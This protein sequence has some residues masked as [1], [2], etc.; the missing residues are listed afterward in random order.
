MPE[1]TPE[2]ITSA[3][4]AYVEAYR[5][6]DKEAL[7]AL[8]APDCEWYDPVGTPGHFGHEGVA[9]FWDSVRQF[10][11]RIV[12]EP[13]ALYVCGTEACMKF[14]IHT[15][16]AGTAMVMEAVDIFTFDEHGKIKVGK[17]YWDMATARPAP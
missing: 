11:D 5:N 2:Q 1:A 9:A 3:C 14:E 8:Y 4:N 16:V 12:L 15:T 10:A 7:L 13:T 6:N 17:A